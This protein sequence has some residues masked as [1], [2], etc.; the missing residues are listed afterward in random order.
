MVTSSAPP[1]AGQHST[2]PGLRTLRLVSAVL[3]AAI[4][5]P[6]GGLLAP[7]PAAADPQYPSVG[8]V[9]QARAAA[10]AKAAELDR[11]RSALAAGAA[12][13]DAARLAAEQ[14]A[15]AYDAAAIELTRRSTASTVAGANADRAAAVFRNSR[16]AVGR[17]AAQ[18]YRNG[19]E[20]GLASAV[21]SSSGLQDLLDR[22]TMLE[23]VGGERVR[24][25]QQM[26]N[27]RI[28]AGWVRQQAAEALQQQQNATAALA[29]AQTAARQAAAEATAAMASIQVEQRSLL[30]Q[31]SAL[32]ATST[33]LER[34]R[35]AG[36][37][38]AAAAARESASR[39]PGRRAQSSNDP[40]AAPA[41][42]G[43]DSGAPYGSAEGTAA[44]G[45]AA[46]AWARQRVGLPYQW[47]GSGPD[48]YDCSGLT[49]RA[50]EQ[51]GVSLPHYAASQYARGARVPYASMRPGDLIFYATDTGDPSSIHH[52]TMYI[53][54]G[55]M[56][57]AP[58]TGANVRIVPV[59]WNQAM[60]RAGRP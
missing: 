50:W 44:S 47:G 42:A 1:P 23:I 32:R 27:S 53:G 34:Q 58:Y 25:M 4:L 54:A 37:A 10:A 9:Q 38:A 13:L 3:S 46:V 16:A 41:D 48:S 51:A 17:L 28:F 8:S 60:P 30:T 56:I 43:G 31:L 12:R 39:R 5:L 40:G 19:A 36:L 20:P 18:A 24:T 52:V 7:W 26:N 22:S 15:E 45:L 6:A 29:A 57:E 11:V 35:L 14:A 33:T 21:L 59:R 55:M 49:M 2:G